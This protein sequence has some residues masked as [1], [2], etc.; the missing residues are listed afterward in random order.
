MRICVF[1]SSAEGL[2]EKYVGSARELGRLIAVRGHELVYGGSRRGLM[3]Q[4]SAAVYEFGGKVIEIIPK[5]WA[6][7]L[8]N[9]G[10]TIITK[11]IARRLNAMQSVSDSFITIPGGLGTLQELTT[12]LVSRQLNLHTKPASILNIDNLYNPFLL[13]LEK[14]VEGGFAPEDNLNL[15]HVASTPFESI[16]YCENYKPYLAKKKV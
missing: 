10:R 9:N 4:V 15:I 14:L 8:V 13:Q 12:V 6:D 3:G 7:V 11:D 1:C 5:M 2:N 16:Q